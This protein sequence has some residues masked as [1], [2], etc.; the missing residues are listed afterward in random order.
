MITGLEYVEV[1]EDFLDAD[2]LFEIQKLS[3]DIYYNQ[4]IV[5]EQMQVGLKQ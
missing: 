1:I 2:D 3:T 5:K 4:N